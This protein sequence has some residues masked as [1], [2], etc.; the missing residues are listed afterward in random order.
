MRCQVLHVWTCAR[1]FN[2]Q[3]AHAR[4][5]RRLS[6]TR[7]PDVADACKHGYL[8]FAGVRAW[9]DRFASD[10]GTDRASPVSTVGR[11]DTIRGLCGAA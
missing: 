3:I 10:L 7:G 5:R 11:F 8:T 6:L 2:T 1:A 4:S 9:V